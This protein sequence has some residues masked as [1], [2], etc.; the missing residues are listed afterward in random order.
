MLG[1]TNF[2]V[3]GLL[4]WETGPVQVL[5]GPSTYCMYV[6]DLLRAEDMNQRG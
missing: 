2:K 6:L 3:Q 1:H 4:F 5:R